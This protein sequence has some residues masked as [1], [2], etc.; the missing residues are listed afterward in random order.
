MI[1]Y[2]R[3][4]RR[5]TIFLRCGFI[6]GSFVMLMGCHKVFPF[7]ALSQDGSIEGGVVLHDRGTVTDDKSR[8][9]QSSVLPPKIP[10]LTCEHPQPISPANLYCYG[11]TIS[12]DG[13]KIYT[14]VKGKGLNQATR[15]PRSNVFENWE[16]VFPEVDDAQDR[17]FF[18]LDDSE[19]SASAVDSAQ[20]IDEATGRPIRYLQICR[21]AFNDCK[22]INIYDNSVPQPQLITVDMDGPAMA[23]GVDPLLMVFNVQSNLSKPGTADIWLGTPDAE[24]PLT[25]Y[26]KP[27]DELNSDVYKEDDPTIS[28]DGKIL[29]FSINNGEE[30]RDNIYAS[31]RENITDEFSEPEELANLNT[32][33]SESSVEIFQR[34]D[35]TIE[36]YFYRRNPEETESRIYRASCVLGSRP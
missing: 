23:D 9:D 20:I 8:L 26:A 35:K 18:Q 16:T 17:T 30:S 4:K 12:T 7:P 11:P 25:W 19:M 5:Y 27:L 3:M 34:E 14:V 15:N 22:K 13:S 24:D 36:I 28:R 31:F 29:L 10:Q 33:Q 21:N 1:N 2:S 32:D 6:C